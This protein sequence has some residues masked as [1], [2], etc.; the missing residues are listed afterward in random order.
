[1]REFETLTRDEVDLAVATAHDAFRHWRRAADLRAGRDRAAAQ[2]S[3]SPSA[4]TSSAGLVTLEMGKLIGESRAGGGPL[5]ATSCAT[6]ATRG[7]GSRRPGRCATEAGDAVL[8]NE[9]IGPLLGVE[10]WNYPLYQV[11]R[12]AGPNLVLGNTIL[13]KHA[14]NCPQ[15][16]LAL[17]ALFRDAGA[18]EGVYT[19]LFMA[20]EDVRH[21]IENPVVQGDR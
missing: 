3:C 16:A 8:V 11:V 20:T 6:T 7:R 15:C 21:V 17:E 13:L 18:P 19:N 14:G 9:P 1:M 5:R 10:P 2:A 12:L 4:A